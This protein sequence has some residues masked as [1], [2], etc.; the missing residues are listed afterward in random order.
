MP[1]Q[2]QRNDQGEVS[3]LSVAGTLDVL[4]APDGA[5][6]LSDDNGGIVYRITYRRP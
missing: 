5:L 3:T 4:T 1:I 2:F 6:Y